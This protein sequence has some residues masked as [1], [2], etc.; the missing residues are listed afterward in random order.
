MYPSSGFIPLSSSAGMGRLI[1]EADQE[2]E[3]KSGH[4]AII[5]ATPLLTSGQDHVPVRPPLAES[6]GLSYVQ[7]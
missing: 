6:G 2:R 5:G 3:L 1:S 4:G 7:M